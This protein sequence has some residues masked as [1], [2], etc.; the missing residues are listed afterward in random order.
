MFAAI[1]VG[2][3]AAVLLSG[4]G[5]EGPPPVPGAI[6]GQRIVCKGL[7]DVRPPKEGRVPLFETS[8]DRPSTG[9]A[10]RFPKDIFPEG[11]VWVAANT[12]ASLSDD[13]VD[14]AGAPLPSEQFRAAVHPETGAVWGLVSV[15]ANSVFE[16]REDGTEA[17]IPGTEGVEV[18]LFIAGLTPKAPA[19][20]G[21]ASAIEAV[22]IEPVPTKPPVIAVPNLTSHHF[23]VNIKDCQYG[24]C[25][26][27]RTVIRALSELKEEFDP[28]FN[29]SEDVLFLN[30]AESDIH[31]N[32]IVG[33]D[34]LLEGEEL[35]RVKAGLPEGAIDGKIV[36]QLPS[37]LNHPGI[38]VILPDNM[39]VENLQSEVLDGPEQA[40]Q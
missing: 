26:L 22:P 12:V 14:E 16:S 9:A 34:K 13:L 17:A 19:A 24:K 33:A 20:I 10:L 32:A 23:T 39:S 38:L 35:D 31:I 7:C 1:A 37:M 25:D 28:S 6:V 27:S 8:T 40:P 5:N 30:P 2:I 3:G 21:A 18:A 36:A 29:P 4:P 11:P 15:T